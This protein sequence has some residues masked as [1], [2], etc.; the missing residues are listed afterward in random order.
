MNAR[1]KIEA[2]KMG[3]V[4]GAPFY[5]SIMLHLDIKEDKSAITAYTDGIALGY[6]PG[7]IDSLSLRQTKSLLAHEVLHVALE[8][9]FRKGERDHKLWNVACDYAINLILKGD[10]Y[11]I[12][13]GWLIDGKYEGMT[14]EQVYAALPKDVNLPQSS[15]SWDVDNP[16][17]GEGDNKKGDSGGKSA[18]DSQPDSDPENNN[19][20]NK[21]SQYSPEMAGEV[22]QYT[23]SSKDGKGK[24][25]EEMQAEWRVRVAQAAETAKMQG[26]LSAGVIRAVTQVL[27]PVISWQSALS[28]FMVENTKNDYTW[29]KPSQRY[30]HSG[31]YLPARETPS[32]G[33]IVV[34]IDT[35][36]SVTEDELNEYAAELSAIL[37]VAPGTEIEVIYADAKVSHVETVSVHDLDLHP[38]G[39]G[40][41]DYAPTFKY[42]DEQGE[43]VTCLIYFTDGWCNSFPASSPEYPTLWVI[44][45]AVSFKPP[46]GETIYTKR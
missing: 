42:V 43:N 15:C 23:P 9:I 30:L 38:M 36:G 41:T 28:R 18:P 32:L 7:Y 10:R 31:Y 12:K 2:A 4:L 24:P 5:A 27:K 39:G 6:N 13:E 22:R 3:L 46:F 1:E 20:A 11:E 19:G 34:A 45:S 33:K 16:G 26:S 35:S 44:N 14:A 8:H 29:S 40:G 37:A 25:T 21:P 17:S